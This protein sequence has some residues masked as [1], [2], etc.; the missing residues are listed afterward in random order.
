MVAGK[1]LID[2][3]EYG[4]HRIGLAE[5]KVRNIGGILR[6]LIIEDCLLIVKDL[7]T[8]HC[9]VRVVGSEE[10]CEGAQS[11]MPQGSP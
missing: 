10:V 7:T 11:H 4:M 2:S 9:A 6:L 5:H 3:T 1:D 8:Q